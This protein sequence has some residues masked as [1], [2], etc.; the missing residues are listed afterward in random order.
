MRRIRLVAFCCSL[1]LAG[2]CY[3]Y[4]AR[5][6]TLTESQTQRFYEQCLSSDIGHGKYMLTEDVKTDLCQCVRTQLETGAITESDLGAASAGDNR[7]TPDLKEKILAN[8]YAPCL[9]TPV[10]DLFYQGCKSDPQISGAV[11]EPEKFCSCVADQVSSFIAENGSQLIET[12]A[13]DQ[14]AI[15]N[16]L[17]TLIKSQKFQDI[18]Q[19]AL[20]T[21]VREQFKKQ[22]LEEREREKQSQ[23]EQEKMDR[24]RERYQSGSGTAFQEK[25]R[26]NIPEDTPT[27]TQEDQ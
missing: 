7:F 24:L 10:H 15:G 26:K 27:I 16:P 14:G 5:A 4:V 12:Q 18:S 1:S 20:L 8:V 3:F 6:E 19:T 11:M 9:H 23:E 22:M 25:E 21:C 2:L 13:G 17:G